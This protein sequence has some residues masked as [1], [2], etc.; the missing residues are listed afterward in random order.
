MKIYTKTGDN[1][2]TSLYD[3]SRVQKSE[4]VFD[5]LGS[6]DELG[7]QMGVL[8][9]LCPGNEFLLLTQRT[10][11]NI[12]S[13]VATPSGNKDFLPRVTETDVSRVE[14]EIDNLDTKLKP[15]NVFLIMDGKTAAS[16]QAHVCRTVCRRVER[17]MEKYGNIDRT[18]TRFTNRLSDYFFTLARFESEV[19]VSFMR[20]TVM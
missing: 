5:V 9:T 7:S 20:C 10:L 12:G 11:L 17:E 14:S 13:I 18:L 16:A 8:L 2:V 19:N 6:L 3:G 15:L 1:G 4:Q